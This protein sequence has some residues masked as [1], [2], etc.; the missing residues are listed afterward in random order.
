MTLQDAFVGYGLLLVILGLPLLA[1]RVKRNRLYGFRTTTTLASDNVWYAANKAAGW[2]LSWAGVLVTTMAV[3]MPRVISADYV[4]VVN[5]A[6]AVGAGV[7]VVIYSF[8]VLQRF[9]S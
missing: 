1:Q 8:K 9:S 7:A 3:W 5:I 4:I 2:A 6:V